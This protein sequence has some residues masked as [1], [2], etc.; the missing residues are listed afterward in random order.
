V[1]V[2]VRNLDPAEP[3]LRRLAALATDR[4]AVRPAI[5]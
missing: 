4:L 1:A 3:A 5:G 2:H